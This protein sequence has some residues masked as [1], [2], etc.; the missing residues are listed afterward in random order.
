MKSRPVFCSWPV[1]TQATCRAKFCTPMVALSSTDSQKRLAIDGP[2]CA[3]SR[4]L[5]VVFPPAFRPECSRENPSRPSPA[6]LHQALFP[7]PHSAAK[8]AWDPVLSYSAPLSYDPPI[9]SDH[10]KDCQRQRN[11]Q[12]V[13]H[14]HT[15]STGPSLFLFH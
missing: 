11:C 12:N 13:T 14:A 5:Q 3:I 10:R 8:T 4:D 7:A 2:F 9:N 6:T 15:G 1:T